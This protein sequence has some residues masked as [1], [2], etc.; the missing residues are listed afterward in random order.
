MKENPAVDPAHESPLPEE[1]FYTA[2]LLIEQGR[3]IEALHLL[4]KTVEYYPAFG[5][6]WNHLGFLYETKFRDLQK[7]EEYYRHALELSPEYTA[8]WLNFAVLLS[9]QERWPELAVLLQR[10]LSVPG[11]NKS[12]V[13]HET[14]I[15]HEAQDELDE[16]IG[17]YQK[18]IGASFS[19]D[20]INR[21][22]K[23]VDRCIRKKDILARSGDQAM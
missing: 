1:M 7:A 20:D 23:S 18:A 22:Q 4:Q 19:E 15:M 8:T 13:Y 5:R 17:Y 16:A 6:A 21:Y 12:K 2:D 14:A 11:I 9:Q 10:S 3:V